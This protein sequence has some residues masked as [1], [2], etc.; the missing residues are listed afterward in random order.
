MMGRRQP[1]LAHGFGE[2]IGM[3]SEAIVRT[4]NVHDDGVV[5]QSVQQGRGEGEVVE[6]L[7]HL[8]SL[9]CWYHGAALVACVDHLQKQ[10]SRGDPR[11]R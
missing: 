1:V 11:A 8:R 5:Q 7:G 4:L 6:H 9:G 3:L 10:V 2:Q